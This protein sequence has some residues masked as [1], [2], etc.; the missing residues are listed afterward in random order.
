MEDRKAKSERANFSFPPSGLRI[1]Q[2][3]E[4]LDALL[5]LA[6]QVQ[7]SSANFGLFGSSIAAT[8][9]AVNLPQLPDFFVDE[10]PWR[11]GKSHLNRPI[12][13]PEKIPINSTVFV[14]LPLPASNLIARRLER[15]MV[16]Y[17]SPA[18]F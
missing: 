3:V 10:D 7:S 1:T 8:W 16:K 18:G 14:S 13:A 2:C 17:A 5:Q 6:A 12:L 15:P 4:W 9:T 11:C